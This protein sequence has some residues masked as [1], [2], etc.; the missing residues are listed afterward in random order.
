MRQDGLV[1]L[2]NR[3]SMAPECEQAPGE[4]SLFSI[5]SRWPPDTDRRDSAEYVNRYDVLSLP[6]QVSSYRHLPAFG[7]L[8]AVALAC[9]WIATMVSGKAIGAERKREA[10]TG[11]EKMAS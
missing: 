3:A 2:D 8:T 5:G 1:W 11:M 9:E 4:G 7:G 10:L 6:R